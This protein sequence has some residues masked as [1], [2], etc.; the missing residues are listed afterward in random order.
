MPSMTFRELTDQLNQES[1]LDLAHEFPTDYE[2]SFDKAIN[3]I[4]EQQP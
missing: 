3:F 1:H 4:L 2:P